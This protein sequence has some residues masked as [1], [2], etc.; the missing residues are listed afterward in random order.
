MAAA[1][2]PA[3]VETGNAGLS[4]KERKALKKRN[5]AM[6]AAGGVPVLS[7]LAH[8]QQ[9]MDMEAAVSRCFVGNLPFKVDEA[10]LREFFKDGG[11]GEITEVFWLTDKESG[12]VRQ[13][14]IGGDRRR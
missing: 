6:A 2:P 14:E 12:K 1:L 13:E 10:T 4:L 11:A 5:A 8:R 7:S 9:V 3:D